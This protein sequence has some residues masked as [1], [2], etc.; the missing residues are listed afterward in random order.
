MLSAFFC[1]LVL[2]KIKLAVCLFQFTDFIHFTW[3]N[4]IDVCMWD[5]INLNSV[6]CSSGAV[7]PWPGIHLQCRKLS[8]AQSHQPPLPHLFRGWSREGHH[9]KCHL[10][11]HWTG[12]TYPHWLNDFACQGLISS[13]DSS[14]K[15]RFLY[16]SPHAFWPLSI[17]CFGLGLRLGLSFYCEVQRYFSSLWCISIF[18]FHDLERGWG[19][20]IIHVI[21]WVSL[22]VI[23]YNMKTYSAE[24]PASY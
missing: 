13:H 7:C 23:Q 9:S 5:D 20:S 6:F 22:R 2:L 12:Y 21:S 18:F 14:K 11:L 1:H 15:N 4:A 16:C 3:L 10:N 24:K 17:H 19:N 8:L